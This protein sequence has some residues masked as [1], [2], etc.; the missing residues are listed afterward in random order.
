MLPCIWSVLDHRGHKKVVRIPVTHLVGPVVSYF[1]IY[2]HV[3]DC[4]HVL[5][6]VAVIVKVS[7]FNTDV[8]MLFFVHSGLNCTWLS[9]FQHLFC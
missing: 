4:L 8:K 9:K 2:L 3:H 6:K 5:L 1:L 7:L